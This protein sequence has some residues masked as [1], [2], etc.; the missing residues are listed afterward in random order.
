ML[1]NRSSYLDIAVVVASVTTV[2][3]V[4]QNSVEAVHYRV[5]WALRH[6]GSDVQE[7]WVTNILQ[8]IWQKHEIIEKR[9][10]T[11]KQPIAGECFVNLCY[12]SSAEVGKP[13]QR[14]GQYIRCSM[15]CEAFGRWHFLFAPGQ[16]IK[17]KESW[18]IIQNGSLIWINAL[19]V[20]LRQ[21]R[22]L[23]RQDEWHSLGTHVGILST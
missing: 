3:R 2:A 23:V 22:V 6:V 8:K 14:E 5:A 12:F 10:N 13:L 1:R 15:D 20:N 11:F 19:Q 9:E 7:F 16:K 21:W 4:H 18:Y 17:K